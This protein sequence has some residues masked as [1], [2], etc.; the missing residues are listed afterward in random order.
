M[1][2]CSAFALAAA[3]LVGPAAA[4]DTTARLAPTWVTATGSLTAMGE[5]YN[6]DGVGTAARPDQ[7]GR[8]TANLTLGFANG[9]ISVPLSAL[10]STDQVTF[11]QNINQLGIS[12]RYRALTFHAG[13][14]APTWSRYTLSDQTLLGGGVEAAPGRLRVGV[15]AGRTR[16]A[17]APDTLAP[18]I[19]VG[20]PAFARWAY[21]A[22]L[23]YGDPQG[24]S[25]DAVV[26]YAADDAGS[27]DSVH[28]A[29]LPG[30][31]EENTVVGATGRVL[32]AGRRL[33]IETRAA[34]AI[35]RR[36]QGADASGDAAGLELRY[37]LGDWTVGGTAEYLG[38]AFRSLGN[39]A[40]VGDRLAYG[41]TLAARLAGGRVSFNGLGGWRH[42]NLDDDLAATSEQALYSLTA[43]LQPVPAFGF[44]L[45]ATNN[46]NEHRPVSDT[47]A[48]RNVTG[49]LGVT[50][51][52][53]WRTGSGQHVL[54]LMAQQQTSENS[55]PG[56]AALIDVTT[57]TFLASWSLTFPSSLAFT[58]TA[59]RTEVELDTIGGTTVTT[60]APGV[61]YALL[62]QRLQLSVQV[63]FTAYEVPVTTGTSREVFPLGQVRYTIARGQ[64][65]TFKS[66]LRH[67][68]FAGMGGEFDE[69]I[70]TLQYTAS[71]R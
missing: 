50:P 19:G 6:R 29:A 39:E 44:D 69:R 61:S 46:V 9:L 45:Q 66:S 57:R 59:T 33:L 13:H 34:H 14:F 67:H 1:R 3:L 10:I 15:V 4:Q 26:L 60:I 47:S 70:F 31:A 37:Q 58:A 17:L 20:Q 55:L 62:A 63:Q 2:P 11:R 51:R 42:N 71:W 56:A 53:M 38:S 21:A 32:T 36:Q 16:K 12:P 28:A 64:S 8:I 30:G 52:F 68:E 49:V 7:T 24:T 22:R 5:L 41:L 48:V 65:V 18:G 25:L 43:T 35:S 27:L 23:G 40:L 54:V